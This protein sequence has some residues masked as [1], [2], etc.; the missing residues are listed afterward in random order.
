MTEFNRRFGALTFPL[1]VD[2]SLERGQRVLL[3]VVRKAI[4]SDFATPWLTLSQKTPLSGENSPVA[5]VYLIEPTNEAIRQLKPKFPALFVFQDGDAQFSKFSAARNAARR[6]WAIEW[7]LG[8][9]DPEQSS[10]LRPLMNALP[11]LISDICLVGG[12]PAY[13]MDANNAHPS[14]SLFEDGPDGG[15]FSE[16]KVVGS[17]VGAASISGESPLY[18]ASRVT[19]ESLEVSGLN[20]LTYGTTPHE[21]ADFAARDEAVDWDASAVD[22]LSVEFESTIT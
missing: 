18:W 8:P 12:H 1:G 11:L 14:Q 5:S 16:L 10:R 3:S 9:L 21:G 7:V 15:G 6:I 22:T 2:G 20:S 17:I 4:E 19:V 13:G